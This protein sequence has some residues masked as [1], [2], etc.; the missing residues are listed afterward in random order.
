[1][2]RRAIVVTGL[3][4]AALGLGACTTTPAPIRPPKQVTDSLAEQVEAARKRYPE[5]EFQP[6]RVIALCYSSQL[7]TMRQVR[8]DANLRCEG[9]DKRLVLYGEDVVLTPCPLFQP[10][11][12]TFLCYDRRYPAIVPRR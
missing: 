7:N 12:I 11:R 8:R 1:M 9:E 6:P 2:S 10:I 5:R 4:L 3:L